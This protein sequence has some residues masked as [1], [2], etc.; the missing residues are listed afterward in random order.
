VPGRGTIFDVSR[1]RRGNYVFVAW[2][3]DHSPRHVH[4]FRRGRLVVKWD[5][6]R[7]RPMSGAAGRKVLSHLRELREEGVL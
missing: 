7:W 5:L 6:D 3:G 2:A 4:V 1:I